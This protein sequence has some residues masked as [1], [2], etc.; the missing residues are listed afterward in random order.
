M[1]VNKSRNALTDSLDNITD[2]DAINDVILQALDVPLAFPFVQIVIGPVGVN[3]KQT[4]RRRVTSQNTKNRYKRHLLGVFAIKTVIYAPMI[5]VLL[6][7][8]Q[9]GSFH[10]NKAGAIHTFNCS[11]RLRRGGVTGRASE[12]RARRC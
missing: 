2:D 12:P 1:L 3:L 4:R 5:T 9:A 7:S 11:G 10:K 8:I 6:D